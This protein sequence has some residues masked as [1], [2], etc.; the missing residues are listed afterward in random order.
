MLV[1][2]AWAVIGFEGLRDYPSLLRVVQDVYA[3]RSVSLST[4]V[5]ALGAPVWAAVAVAAAAGLG[6]I[7]VAA[8]LV[9]GDDGDRRAFTVLVAASILASA[10][11]WPNYLACCWS[12]SRSPGPA[13]AAAW[14]FG[15]V[16]WIAGAI[17]PKATFQRH[18]LP[19]AGRVSNRCR[20]DVALGAIAPA[21][22]TT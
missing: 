17:A 18:L 20:P 11:V 5:G 1:L 6:C 4:V 8:W 22:Q 2:G 3:V 14:F 15:Y 21:N 9:R 13:S 16:V 19:T 12:R 7:A 10:I